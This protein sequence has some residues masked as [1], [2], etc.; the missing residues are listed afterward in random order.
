MSKRIELYSADPD[1]TA[2]NDLV[3]LHFLYAPAAQDT[4][5]HHYTQSDE[6]RDQLIAQGWHYESLAGYD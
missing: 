3:Q 6:E 5:S 1:E 4:G 2:D